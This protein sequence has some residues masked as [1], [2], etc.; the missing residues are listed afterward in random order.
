MDLNHIPV[1]PSGG[2]I[3]IPS[4]QALNA[5]ERYD[6]RADAHAWLNIL[7]GL[8][9]LY[10]WS[11]E[12]C[13]TIASLRMTGRAQTWLQTRHHAD[14]VDFRRSFLERFGETKETAIARFEACFQYPGESPKA[15]ADRYL[16][17][18]KK[19]GRAADDTTVYSF[20]K[21]LQPDLRSEAA[22]HRFD[23]IDDAV[24][25][26]N[27][28]LAFCMPVMAPEPPQRAADTPHHG[29]TETSYVGRPPK[30]AGYT[31]GST[32]F[33]NMSEG[34][35][36]PRPPG[37]RHPFQDLGNRNRGPSQPT[38]EDVLLCDDGVI[39][40][41]AL[42]EL[43]HHFEILEANFTEY[44]DQQL[45][46]KDREISELRH[47]LQL[48]SGNHAAEIN[49]LHG[50]VRPRTGGRPGSSAT[51]QSSRK[52]PRPQAHRKRIL[53]ENDGPPVQR[54]EPAHTFKRSYHLPR[55]VRDCRIARFEYERQI[56]CAF[57]KER[58]QAR[59]NGDTGRSAMGA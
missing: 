31:G 44:V 53:Q 45:A 34:D 49:Y 8:A 54:C 4:P 21:R 18:M 30:P 40:Q 55:L 36:D 46:E 25:Y 27:Y 9:Q 3:N 37:Y 16:Q 19:A 1:M 5:V 23:S 28:W 2:N 56:G 14:W 24:S 13:L 35:W 50:V 41:A 7:N 51:F 11:D 57:D 20:I 39:S 6:G 12:A 29:A 42:D 32:R 15:F 59:L 22:R 17:Y 10:N 26:C 52:Y 38:S 48:A 58:T 43:A 47:A 33:G